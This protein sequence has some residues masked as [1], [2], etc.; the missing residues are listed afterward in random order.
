MW[1]VLYWRKWCGIIENV[2][3]RFLGRGILSP[4][5]INIREFMGAVRIIYMMDNL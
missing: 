1:G 3:M 2:V 4:F 5:L